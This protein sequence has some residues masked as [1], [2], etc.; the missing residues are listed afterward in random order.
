M[1]LSLTND[2]LAYIVTIVSR[3]FR[4]NSSVVERDLAKVDVAGPTPVSRCKNDEL[5][6]Y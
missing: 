6:P 4:G 2:H 1:I 3:R 5:I